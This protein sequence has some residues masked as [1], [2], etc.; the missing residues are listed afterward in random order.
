MTM[1][2]DR[3]EQQLMSFSSATK[4]PTTPDLTS[5]FWRRLEATKTR[6]PASR[7]AFAGAA[8]AAVVV[9]V[10]AT[11]ALAAPARDAAADL[12]H[13]I[14]IFET[15]RSTEGLP[16][17]ITG[18]E[19]TLEEAE[20]AIGN[21]RQPTRPEGVTLEKVLLQDYGDVETAALFYR[22]NDETFVLFVSNA[23]P[24][25][26]IPIG[27]DATV[28]EVHTVGDEAYW[29]TG[30]RIVQSLKPNGEV[31]HGSERVTDANALIWTS[32]VDHY[33]YRIEGNIERDEAIRIAQSVR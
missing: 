29:L 33:T 25:K 32:S 7:L 3:L 20:S 31:A 2:T 11:F 30:Q 15:S 24:G 27:G 9:A 14:N 4:Y 13:G 23:F 21:I 10:S 12:W 22:A 26:G 28:E 16:T 17:Y 18:T 8:L 19:T 5:G 1:N 6:R